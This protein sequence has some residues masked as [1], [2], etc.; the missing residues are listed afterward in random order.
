MCQDHS[1]PA[2]MRAVLRDVE[3]KQP[4]TLE[5]VDSVEIVSL[6]DNVTDVFMPDQ[7]PAHRPQPMAARRPAATMEGGTALDALL[8]EHGFSVLVTVTK[9][10]AAHRILFDTGT[11]PD[12]VVENMRRL[13]IDPSDIEAIVCSHGHFDHTTGLDGLKGADILKVAPGL[14]K[15]NVQYPNSTIAQ[16]LKGVSKIGNRFHVSGMREGALPRL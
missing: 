2:P 8:A 15:S 11:S 6:M 1:P 12:G 13:E 5:P 16:K 7:G 3:V 4:I 14:Y 10:G 9:N